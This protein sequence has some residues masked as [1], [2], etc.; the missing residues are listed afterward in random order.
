MPTIFFEFHGTSTSVD[1]QAQAVGEQK[2]F[3][4]SVGFDPFRVPYSPIAD[5]SSTLCNVLA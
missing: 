3:P 1:D 4:K 2:P 5:A